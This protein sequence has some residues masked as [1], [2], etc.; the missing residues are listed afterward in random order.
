MRELNLGD[1]AP[2]FDLET[3]S[4][5]IRLSDL[6]GRKVVVFFYPK[7][8]TTG[9]TAEAIAF[10]AAKAEFEATGATVI[11]VS[12][13]TVKS[14]ARFRAKHG[15]TVELASDLDTA[16]MQ[17]WGVWMEKTLYGRK[18]MGADRSTFLIDTDGVIRQIWRKV[19]VPGHVD[20]VLAATKTL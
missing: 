5:R 9:C 17:A 10:S 4:G 18:Y 6:R 14:H 15:L 11:G 1:A 19:K 3:D 20:A 12:K 8:D 16:M 13:D 7:D 2:D